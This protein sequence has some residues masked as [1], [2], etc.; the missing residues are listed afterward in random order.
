MSKTKNLKQSNFDQ[1]VF[2]G[3]QNALCGKTGEAIIG[4]LVSKQDGMVFSSSPM[5][6]KSEPAYPHLILMQEPKD[7]RE[8]NIEPE[9][10]MAGKVTNNGW[11]GCVV[12]HDL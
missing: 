1:S 7:M 9:I 4:L 2:F 8:K 5:L 6:S 12:D 10:Y 11:P 3:E